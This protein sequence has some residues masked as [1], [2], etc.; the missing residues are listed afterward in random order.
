MQ[1]AQHTTTH[2][3]HPT[4]AGLP[5]PGTELRVVDPVNKQIPLPDGTPGLLLARG[6][7]VMGGYYKDPSATAAAFPIGD[8]WF[9]TGDVGWRVPDDNGSRMAGM[10]ILT[11]RAKDTIVLS[12]GKNVEPQPLED[13][14][15]VSAYI[16]HAVVAGSDHRALGA[17]VAPD[18]DALQEVG[19]TQGMG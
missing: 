2:Y 15:C 14:C 13:A 9:D 16:K 19:V 10:I 7:G 18:W 12:S 1:Y 3:I 11:G 17:L 5:I 6:P 4:T 8:G